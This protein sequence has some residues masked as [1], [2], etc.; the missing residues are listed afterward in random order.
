MLYTS[1]R[2]A[3]NLIKEQSAITECITAVQSRK[4]RANT[5]LAIKMNIFC[6]L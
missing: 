4:K 3:S 5:K 2:I 1:P 6:V